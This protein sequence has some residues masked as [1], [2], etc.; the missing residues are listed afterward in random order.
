ME[1]NSEKIEWDQVL[2]F[3]DL[4]QYLNMSS[5]IELSLTRKS[6]RNKLKS[7]LFNSVIL[8]KNRFLD[9]FDYY[10]E[11]NKLTCDVEEYKCYM[12][13]GWSSYD[14]YKLKD[15]E[16]DKILNSLEINILSIKKYVKSFKLANISI[17]G[18][19]IF[20]LVYKFDSLE[21]LEVVGSSIPL[22]RLAK[23]GDNFKNLKFLSLYNTDIVVSYKEEISIEMVNIPTGLKELA[24]YGSDIDIYNL[25][26][27]LYEM[28]NTSPRTWYSV[29]M[30]LPMPIPSLE[31]FNFN[32]NTWERLLLGF[33]K[34]NSHIKSL[35]LKSGQISQDE[36]N[37]IANSS[38]L[39]ELSIIQDLDISTSLSIPIFNFITN[40]KLNQ[41]YESHHY[42]AKICE[43]CPNLTSLTLNILNLNIKEL[44]FNNMLQT[45]AQN[46]K[47]LKKF[48]LIVKVSG[49]GPLY[50]C[51]L[52]S[53]QCFIIRNYSSGKFNINSNQLPSQFRNIKV[54]SL[55]SGKVMILNN[56]NILKH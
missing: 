27:N 56:K 34:L 5:L 16:H 17:L 50:F 19:F 11:S 53:I 48:E 35:E 54:E 28:A 3:N 24:I 46:L 39:T 51:C 1:S 30:P 38:N 14:I 44:E 55:V 42:G 12:N 26:T 37:Y 22:I 15:V 43:N 9:Y 7:L 36:L 49:L 18:Y 8:S 6:L 32:L 31:K 13:R 20:P 25:T 33:L 45:M 40:L 2:C 47:M 21:R 29:E 41:F 4:A 10:K 23:L 52:N